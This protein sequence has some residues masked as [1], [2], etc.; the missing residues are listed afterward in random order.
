MDADVGQGAEFTDGLLLLIGREIGEWVLAGVV[1]VGVPAD[2]DTE[3]GDGVRTDD[4]CIRRGEIDGADLRPLI[5]VAERRAVRVDD[6]DVLVVVRILKP[7][8]RVL[9]V[10]VD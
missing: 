4:V 6:T 8:T 7:G 3:I 2:K 1:V 5:C 9:G 10:K